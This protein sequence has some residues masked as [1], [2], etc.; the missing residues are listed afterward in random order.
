MKWTTIAFVGALALCLPA[1]HVVTRLLSDSYMTLYAGRWIAAHGIPHHEVFTA[2]AWGRPWIDQQWL[3]E[4]IDYEAWR[5]GGYGAL[6]VLN[7]AAIAGAYAGLAAILM[8]RG[9]SMALTVAACALAVFMALP[10]VFIRAQDL[11]LPLFVGLLALC[12]SDSE[13]DRPR[14]HVMLVV[15]LLVLWANLH[16]SVLVG[17]GL[18]C[19]YLAYRGAVLIRH[20]HRAGGVGYW[21]L[22]AVVTLTPLATPYGW[23]IVEY[24]RGLIGNSGVAA[25]APEDRPPSL[26]DPSAVWFLVAM[27]T[28][29][30]AL[31]AS[32]LRRQRVAVPLIGFTAL[33]AGATMVASRNVVWF[34]M[35][36]A[37]LLVSIAQD[38]LPTELPTRRFVTVM[39]AGA[40]GVAVLGVGWLVA[41]GGGG[42]ESYTPLRAIA[43]AARYASA[44]PGARILG[45]NAAASALL[46]HDPS[47][48]GRVAW[49]ARLE[50][51]SA[52]SLERWIA[53]QRGT[54]AA[55]PATTRGYRLLLGATRY[56]QSLVMRLGSMSGYSVLARDG[57][58]IAVAKR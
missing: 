29:V 27:A 2:G 25:A 54:G 44:H 28:T 37:V 58:G 34:G 33:T 13:R 5:A 53:Y 45:D 49:D 31:S 46:W 3:A 22:A 41:P 47:V 23:H 9:A 21:A 16:G 52:H 38:W 10:A 36:A 39:T 4:I 50:R 24:Y 7:A 12:L 48:D 18:A 43:A 51:Y 1:W 35:A 14:A 26:W 40:A 30:I 20:G 15:P 56:D 55:W 57:S 17:V 19:A 11:A 8:R 6:G 42:Y 32:R